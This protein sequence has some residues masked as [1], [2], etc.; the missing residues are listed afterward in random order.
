M[1]N[2]DFHNELNVIDLDMLARAEG[3]GY[4]RE[5]RGAERY[6]FYRRK[7]LHCHDALD[8]AL[9]WLRNTADQSER[10]KSHLTGCV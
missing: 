3:G 6:S 2:N 7:G 4:R 8:F 5:G 10:R 1:A 9:A